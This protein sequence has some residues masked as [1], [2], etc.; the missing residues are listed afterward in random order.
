MTIKAVHHIDTKLCLPIFKLYLAHLKPC[1]LF[2]KLSLP[3]LNP[4]LPFAEPSLP[5]SKP[6]LPFLKP[7]QDGH[8][9]IIAHY[10]PPKGP[11]GNNRSY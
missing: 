4:S 6:S 11:A 1:L 2:S 9:A 3:F 7:G 10:P 5:V 8:H